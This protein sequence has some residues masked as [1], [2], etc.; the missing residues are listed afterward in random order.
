MFSPYLQNAL[1][2]RVLTQGIIRLLLLNTRPIA[3]NIIGFSP[4]LDP[5][6]LLASLNAHFLV[7]LL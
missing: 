7:I 4:G 1:R 3:V 2:S 5:K 6:T